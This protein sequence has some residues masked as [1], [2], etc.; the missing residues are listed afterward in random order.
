VVLVA[1][2]VVERIVWVEALQNQVVVPLHG[3]FI[4][5]SS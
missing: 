5:I 4:R 2:K 1:N 3:Q